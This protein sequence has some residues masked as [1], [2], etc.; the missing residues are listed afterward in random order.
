MR[1]SQ[2][3]SRWRMR[4][5][6]SRSRSRNSVFHSRVTPADCTRSSRRFL[7]QQR[8]E[9]AKDVAA[10][11]RI[12][13]VEDRPGAHDRFGA[14]EQVLDPHQV[15]V[16]QHRLQRRQPS[17]AGNWPRWRAS[18]AF[19]YC[20]PMRSR[21]PAGLSPR[22]SCADSGGSRHCRSGPCHRAAAG[23]RGWRQSPRA[24]RGRWWLRFRCGK[25]D[26]ARAGVPDLFDEELGFT[27]PP[28]DRQ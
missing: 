8:Q 7:Q 9:R 5:C 25:R 4:S 2:S 26:I 10:D 17:D 15:A 21:R 14:A 24:R 11:R 3:A 12:A 19:S 6:C 27:L 18:T 23:C 22:R 16:A 1:T 28:V 13:G 20:A